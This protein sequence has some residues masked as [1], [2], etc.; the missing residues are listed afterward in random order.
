M[1]FVRTHVMCIV[2]SCRSHNRLLY[3]NR[4]TWDHFK[5]IRQRYYAQTHAKG[6]IYCK[7]ARVM[8]NTS[9]SILSDDRLMSLLQKCPEGTSF[10]SDDVKEVCGFVHVHSCLVGHNR[11]Y[12]QQV[13]ARYVHR[14]E[15][16]IGKDNQGAFNSTLHNKHDKRKGGK[17]EQLRAVKRKIT[18]QKKLVG[19]DKTIE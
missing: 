17:F 7:D 2:T 6:Q 15:S 1:L 12:A 13:F 5:S 3:A 16:L 11:W 14:S 4:R 19:G 10:H 9:E 8:R 18:T